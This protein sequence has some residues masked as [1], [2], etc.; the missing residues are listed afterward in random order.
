M[1]RSA[2]A[3]RRAWLR[4][5]RYGA[6][7]EASPVWHE[8]AM[9]FDSIVTVPGIVGRDIGRLNVAIETA[10]RVYVAVVRG[11]GSMEGCQIGG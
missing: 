1:K 10:L 9:R 8:T 6:M 4:W 2:G 5:F 7:K 3:R 11:K